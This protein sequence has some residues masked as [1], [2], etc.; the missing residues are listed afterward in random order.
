MKLS[1]SRRLAVMF[2]ASGFLVFVLFG[3]VLN[4]LFQRQLDRYQCTELITRLQVHRPLVAKTVEAARWEWTRSKLDTVLPADGRVRLWV[5]SA[6]PR[7]RYGDNP[8]SGIESLKPNVFG[9]LTVPGLEYP[10]RTLMH[11]IPAEGERPEVSMVVGVDQNPYFRT[12]HDL[13]SAL[14]VASIGGML[15]VAGLG[16]WIAQIGLRPLARLSDEAKA[17]SPSKLAARLQREALPPELAELA[18]SFNGAL[19]R[20]ESTYQQ[21]EAFNADVAHEL[22]TPLTNL[23]GLTQVSLSRERSADELQ[24]VLESNLEELNRLRAIINDMLFLARADQGDMAR[25]RVPTSLAR[26]VAKTIEFLDVVLDEAGVK[27]RLEGD[28]QIAVETALLGRA[29]NNLLLNAVQHCAQGC[30]VVASI[31][32]FQDDVRVAVSNPGP[33]I[34]VDKRSRL[35]ARFYRVD[36]ARTGG[37]ENHG[38]GLAIVKAIAIMHGGEV[39]VTS[40]NHVNTFGFTLARTR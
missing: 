20:V 16:Y 10:M 26:E 30:E 14:I 23:I 1:I 13:T 8:P 6:D 24:D 34:P 7:F 39:F 27:V 31:Q 38:L 3:L 12:A 5:V 40:E 11:R 32:Q 35:F 36:S 29:M 28:A 37:H 9:T 25:N 2:A 33:P 18:A 17:L 22:R 4:H 19:D 15:L 21:L